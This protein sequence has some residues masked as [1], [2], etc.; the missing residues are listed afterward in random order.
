MSHA[1]A[2]DRFDTAAADRAATI[3]TGLFSA[4]IAYGTEGREGLLG[5]IDSDQPIVAGMAAVYSLRY[6]QGRSR[7][8]LA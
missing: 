3:L 4:I 7:P 1:A 5:L 2:L 6:N 8:V